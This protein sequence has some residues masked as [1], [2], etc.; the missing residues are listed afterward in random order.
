MSLSERVR[1]FNERIR[2]ETNTPPA[3]EPPPLRK[4]GARFRT[5]PVTTEEVETAQNQRLSPLQAS[6]VKPPDS[7][8]FGKYLKFVKLS[9]KSIYIIGY[10]VYKRKNLC[11]YSNLRTY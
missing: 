1:L 4:R 2:K 7:D 6:L 8:L 3:P 11:N 10:G 5:Q 9:N